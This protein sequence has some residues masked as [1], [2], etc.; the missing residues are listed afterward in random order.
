MRSRVMQESVV[1]LLFLIGLGV[2][3]LAL[4][5]L[6]GNLFA[7]QTYEVTIT[8]ADAPGLV[9]GTPV[10]YRGVRVGS[11]SDV[12][13]GP[14]GIIAKAKLRDVIIPR[15]AIPEVRQSGF[16]G[17]SFLDFRQVV[18][19]ADL[20]E[21][22]SPVSA[23]CDPTIIICNGKKIQG[24]TGKSLDDLITAANAI[25][26]SLDQSQLIENTNSAITKVATAAENVNRLSADARV[27]LREFST[28]ARSV[29]QAANQVTSLVEVNKGTL[30]TTLN[31]LSASGQ[32]LKLVLGNLSP[33][34][35]RLEKSTVLADLE[36]LLKNGSQA[37]ANL[38]TISGTL[39]NPAVMFSLAQTLD[40]ARAT[41]INTQKITNDLVKLSGD[42]ELQE[43]LRRLIRGLSRLFSSS[44]EL[45]Q[46]LLALTQQSQ[47]S[48]TPPASTHHPNQ[49]ALAPNT[50][51]RDAEIVVPPQ[52][53]NATAPPPDPEPSPL[54][55]PNPS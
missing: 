48:A 30:T 50:A 29:T 34:L 6:R 55:S 2:L 3:G 17:S 11:I 53:V 44:L 54:L 46:Q 38:N 8:L 35:N 36:A 26:D 31:T 21:N 52:P 9:V 51:H 20:P 24:R 23:D 13:V 28:A 49:P 39:S 27:Q 10:R 45:E 5:W 12:Q 32:E 22:L 43:D 33:F 42:Q 7:G 19:V 1:G 14:M 15:D 40:A 37:A 47:V 16:V 4:I 18:A 41:F 25:A